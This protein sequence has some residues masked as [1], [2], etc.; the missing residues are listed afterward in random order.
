MGLYKSRKEKRKEDRQNKKIKNNL[1]NLFK[2]GHIK[3]EE[4]TKFNNKARNDFKKES[5]QRKI[6]HDNENTYKD[7]DEDEEDEEINSDEASFSSNNESSI[8]KENNN[9]LLKKKREN[10]GNNKNDYIDKEIDEDIEYLEG[11]LKIKSKKNNENYKKLKVKAYKD[12]FDKDIFDFLDNIDEIPTKINEI[13]EKHD[14]ISPKQPEKQRK[15]EEKPESKLNKTKNLLSKDLNILFNK[16]SESNIQYLYKEFIS[17]LNLKLQSLSKETQLNEEILIN[18]IYKPLSKLIIKSIYENVFMNIGITSCISAYLSI[19]HYYLGDYF[20]KYFLV[21]LFK[22]Y[23]LLFNDYLLSNEINNPNDFHRISNVKDKIDFNDSINNENSIAKLKNF[24]FILIFLFLFNN[25]SLKFGYE[26]IISQILNFNDLLSNEIYI[27]LSYIGILLRKE[28]PVF[29]SEIYKLI[30]NK[31]S[32]SMMKYNSDMTMTETKEKSLYNKLVFVKEVLEDIKNNKYLKFNV[33]ENF[34][35]F[36]TLIGNIRKEYSLKGSLVSSIVFNSKISKVSKENKENYKK[37]L[38]KVFY[39]TEKLEINFN[40]TI[41]FYN[42]YYL[43]NESKDFSSRVV[44]NQ[45]LTVEEYEFTDC[46]RLFSEL[47]LINNDLN[48]KDNKDNKK[49]KDNFSKRISKSKSESD[50]KDKV[51][52]EEEEEDNESLS[53]LVSFDSEEIEKDYDTYKFDENHNEKTN[54]SMEKLNKLCKR[55]RI[56]TDLKKN[57]LL[58]IVNSLDYNDSYEKLIKLNLNKEQTREIIKILVL[59]SINEKKYNPY[60]ALILTKLITY[61]RD[62]KY[63]FNYTIWDYLRNISD[64]PINGIEILPKLIT[65]LILKDKIS[66]LAFVPIDLNNKIHN[67]ILG[68]FMKDYLLQSEYSNLKIQ[69]TRLLKNDEQIEF[70]KKIFLFLNEQLKNILKNEGFDQVFYNE[71]FVCN[72]EMMFKL[73]KKVI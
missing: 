70:F 5:F 15:N 31:L 18:E 30:E 59:L 69:V 62:N 57:I 23:S 64:V 68:L 54:S 40:K 16:S 73:I 14:E 63:T 8:D 50:Q 25:L 71:T 1:S 52:E 7:Y 9:R 26:L 38:E 17:I 49:N 10:E 46:K 53:S 58:C 35:F 36:M 66:L 2:H 19:A 43:S 41:L 13:L 47:D 42:N 3:Y 32:S 37:F 20:I 27:I 24:G 56:N 12:N 48:D 44:K 51:K 65:D 60:Y 28:N 33:S 55:L 39:S 67:K 21:I 6:S 34:S 11:K 45:E 22:Q 29:I 61:D 4:F 72:Y